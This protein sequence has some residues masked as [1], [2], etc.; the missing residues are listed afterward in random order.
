MLT[1]CWWLWVIEKCTVTPHCLLTLAITLHSANILSTNCHHS[2]VAF[3][4]PSIFWHKCSPP[5]CGCRGPGPWRHT[6]YC[7]FHF[8]MVMT[9]CHLSILISSRTNLVVLMHS[10]HLHNVFSKVIDLLT[11]MA[12][13][14]QVLQL[15]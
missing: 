14:V 2:I 7:S 4:F 6:I 5:E 1:H 10:A 8:C 15:Y 3:V 12:F 13:I 11:S 9:N